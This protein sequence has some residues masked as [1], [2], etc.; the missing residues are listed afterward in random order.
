MLLSIDDDIL[1]E[2]LNRFCFENNIPGRV[3]SKAMRIQKARLTRIRNKKAKLYL[4]E[5]QAIIR[6][7]N[8][9]EKK[10]AKNS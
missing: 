8:L 1:R 2:K 4:S 7:T 3:A 6:F 9:E 5:A 10:W